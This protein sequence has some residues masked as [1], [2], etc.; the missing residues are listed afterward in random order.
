MKL[1]LLD[2]Y[3]IRA[4]LSASVILLSPI[5]ITA[6][7]C[8]EEI[9]AIISS[10]VFV[11][12]LLAFT[13]YI[14][15]LQRRFC[16]SKS[17]YVDS[18]TQLLLPSNSIINATTKNRYYQK[19]S[20]VDDSF[21]LFEYPNESDEFKECCDSAVSYLKENTRNDHHVQ[22][23][24]INYG[25]CKNLLA[26]KPFGIL[27]TI[28]L[29]LVVVIF[30]FVRYNNLAAIPTNNYFAFFANIVMLVFWLLG[31]NKKMLEKSAIYYAKTLLSKIDC[32]D[33]K[34]E[35]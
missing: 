32:L 13:N 30:S 17:Y 24:N 27:L 9:N 19:L 2:A 28:F 18:A 34:E 16:Q 5:A 11:F 3:Y 1:D 7:L 12:I 33:I 4:R 26:T 35:P 6:F 22:E 8:F 31:I 29:L 14:P 20:K 21:K 15:L 25:F 23:E 10:S